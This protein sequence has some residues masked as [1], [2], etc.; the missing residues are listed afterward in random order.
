VTLH[1]GEEKL[2]MVSKSFV[3]SIVKE[4]ASKCTTCP[5]HE[6]RT[7]SVFS[8]GDRN[9]EIVFIGE[10]P[11]QTENQTG[12]PFCGRSGKLLDNMIKAMGYERNEVYIC[13]ICKC[14][15]PDNRKP[16]SEEMKRCEPFLVR[17]LELVKPK[18]IVTLGATAAEG[19]LG[20]GLGITKRR[21]SWGEF[22]G[23]KVMPTFHPAACLYNPK[24][25]ND[26]WA[27]LQK[28]M[29]YI[30]IPLQFKQI[31]CK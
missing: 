3:L 20:P 8:R 12:E 23:I 11:G 10:A 19:I 30:G 29:K 28:V 25:K 13:N 7:N 2:G 26:V 1:F 9:A 22:E 31:T 16:T 21:G 27:D 5:L 18:V 6:T 24:L 14:R 17:Q 4:A 15:P